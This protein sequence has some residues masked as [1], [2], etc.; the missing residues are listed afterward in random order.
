MILWCCFLL[1][2]WPLKMW[3]K[4]AALV[5]QLEGITTSTLLSKEL[6]NR[7][8]K[9]KIR[10]NVSDFFFFFFW[11]ALCWQCVGE[12]LKGFT[13]NS[14]ITGWGH[15][16]LCH[17]L[18]RSLVCC[19]GRWHPWGLLWHGQSHCCPH[20]PCTFYCARFAAVSENWPGLC[21]HNNYVWGSR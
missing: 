10:W 7:F 14:S 8:L 13:H 9:K 21:F 3:L 12:E 18:V 15:T 4:N 2:Y 5:H 17:H 16:C 11:F 20:P 6:Y 1:E 19:V